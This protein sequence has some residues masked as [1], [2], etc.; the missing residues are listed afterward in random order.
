MKV[1]KR[2]ILVL[3]VFLLIGNAIIVCSQIYEEN[4]GWGIELDVENI[5]SDGVKLHMKRGNDSSGVLLHTWSYHPI[6]KWTLFGW[7][8]IK[9][10][11][12]A[13][14]MH[15]ELQEGTEKVWHVT[16]EERLGV[17]LYRISKEA[18]IR[19]YYKETAKKGESL[20]MKWYKLFFVTTWWEV[21]LYL[22]AIAIVV[23]V[24]VV[25]CK[26]TWKKSKYILLVLGPIV[27]LVYGI[28]FC[29]GLKNEKNE[30]N[31]TIDEI[32]QEQIQGKYECVFEGRYASPRMF[33]FLEKKT[34]TGWEPLVRVNGKAS[35]LFFDGEDDSFGTTGPLGETKGVFSV[36]LRDISEELSE[37]E[38]RIKQPIIVLGE[39]GSSEYYVSEFCI[40]FEIDK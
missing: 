2:I 39:D 6:E 29:I 38:Y 30:I 8:E 9:T 33:Y 7:K 36:E 24:L 35:T 23:T 4:S 34:W 18:T 13:K 15:Y 1:T 22:L 5:T 32:T 40:E 20:D 3:T 10:K 11:Q 25:L 31:F 37:G 26:V 12:P 27:L 28:L 16:A 21:L 14:E 19:D 17:G